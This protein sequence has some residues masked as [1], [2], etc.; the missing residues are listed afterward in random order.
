MRGGGHYL[1]CPKR[2]STPLV[3]LASR[4]LGSNWPKDLGPITVGRK[5]TLKLA[6]EREVKKVDQDKER[7]IIGA[8]RVGLKPFSL[9]HRKYFH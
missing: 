8:L 2:G 7:L 5:S 1:L 9:S 6:Q 3:L 4:D